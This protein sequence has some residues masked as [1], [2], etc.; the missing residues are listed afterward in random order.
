M[1]PANSVRGP[2]T[3]EELFRYG[4]AGA[5]RKTGVIRERIDAMRG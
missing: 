2:S 1:E 5:I 3:F 4:I